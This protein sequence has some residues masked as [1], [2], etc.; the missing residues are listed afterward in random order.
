MSYEEYLA[1]TQKE[2]NKESW[3][4]WKFEICG[5]SYLEAIREANDPDC[6]YEQ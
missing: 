4:D 1:K 3:I 6:G 2:D 5:M